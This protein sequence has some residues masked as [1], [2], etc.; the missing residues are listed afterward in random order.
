MLATEGIPVSPNGRYVA[1]PAKVGQYYQLFRLDVETRETHQITDSPGDK[2]NA[3]WS[4]DGRSIIYPSNASGDIQLWRIPA[5]GGKPQRLTKGNDRIRHAFY[6]SDGRWIYFQPNH[7]NIY[8]MPA[9]GGPVQQ[10]TRFP[11]A[12]LFMEEPNISPDNRYLVY[13]RSNGGSSLWSLKISR[14]KAGVN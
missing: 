3:C 1:Y 2:F 12:G 11:E 7:M 5:D 6:S 8:R 13:S 4:R 9:D 14:G 10:V